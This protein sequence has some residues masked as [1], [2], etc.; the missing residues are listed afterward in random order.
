MSL[1][2]PVAVETT[3]VD[4]ATAVPSASV[5]TFSNRQRYRP[6]WE[7]EMG[8][9]KESLLEKEY[10][11][12]KMQQAYWTVEE[13]NGWAN[14]ISRQRKHYGQDLDGLLFG[15]NSSCLSKT[16]K[17]TSVVSKPKTLILNGQAKQNTTTLET[18]Q[19]A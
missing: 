9:L 15:N 5:V 10:H 7:N 14:M 3:L 16:P 2:H 18:S 8:K 17:E 12:Q 19:K 6:L 13:A 11:F 1:A 4:I